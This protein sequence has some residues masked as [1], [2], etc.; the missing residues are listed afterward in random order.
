[1]TPAM[2]KVTTTSTTTGP[3]GAAITSVKLMESGPVPAVTDYGIYRRPHYYERQ[4]HSW[5]GTWRPNRVLWSFD[6]EYHAIVSMLFAWLAGASPLARVAY[7][8]E[9]EGRR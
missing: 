4:S 9:R 5:S 6:A 8:L 3:G 7:R 2:R 1:M